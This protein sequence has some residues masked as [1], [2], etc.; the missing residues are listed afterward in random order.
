MP[1]PSS[2]SIQTSSL[3][4]LLKEES[5][6]HAELSQQECRLQKLINGPTDSDE[7]ENAE[8]MIRQQVRIFFSSSVVSFLDVVG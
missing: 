6:Y 4:R 8:F 5:S 2:L 7:A 3:L 1:P